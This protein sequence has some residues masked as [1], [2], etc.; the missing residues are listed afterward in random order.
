VGAASGALSTTQQVGYA[1][2]V[3]VTGVVFFGADG[4]IAHAF[5]LSRFQLLVPAA[6]V[7]A[8]SRLLPA[9]PPRIAAAPAPAA[10]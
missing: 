3:A 4:G 10:A 8:A 9:R 1:L 2:G 7:V 5:Q 6:G